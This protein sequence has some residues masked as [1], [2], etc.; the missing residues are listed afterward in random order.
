MTATTGFCS[1]QHL[2][3]LW[4]GE[5][6]I[7]TPAPTFKVGQTVTRLISSDRLP[8]KVKVVAIEEGRIYCCPPAHNWAKTECWCFDAETLAEI[9]EFLGW[10]G[11]GKTG[12]IL[13]SPE[14]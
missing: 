10:D 5:Y 8:M 4:T 9:D 11:K 1:E 6:M 7:P 13:Q 14:S 3:L 2:P 12:S